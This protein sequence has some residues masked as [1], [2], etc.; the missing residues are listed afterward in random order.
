M[1]KF[2]T[3][4]SLL[5][6]LAVSAMA[7]SAD[8]YY[9]V[10]A[11]SHTHYPGSQWAINDAGTEFVSTG[12]TTVSTDA[13]KH[14]AFVNYENATYIYSV[15]AKK[16]VM[17]DKFL[18]DDPSTVINNS[19]QTEKLSDG[20]YFFKFDNS[21]IINIGGSGQMVI[22][23]WSTKDGGNQYTLTEQ[24]D[25][26]ASEAL[27]ILPTI[28]TITYEFKYDDKV[29]A[30]T[31]ILTS[32]NEPYPACN[33]ADILPLGVNATPPSGI[34][35]TDEKVTIN[36]TIDNSQIPFQYAD[37]YASIE[38][39][40]YMNIRDDGPT[41]LQYDASKNYI[42][43]T[44][45]SVPEDQTDNYTWGFIGDPVNGFKI[46]NYAAGE[47][48]VLSSPAT[49]TGTQNAG[50][51]ARMVAAEGATGNTTWTIMVPNHDNP[52]AENGFYIQH[53][54]AT[55]YA[56]NRQDYNSAKT[57]CYWT[58]RDTGSTLQVVE[59]PMTNARE[60]Q[61]LVEQAQEQL[62]QI[63]IGE[64]V[65]KYSSSYE[66]YETTYSEIIAY[67]QNIPATATSN[68]I[69]SKIDILNA[70]I[71]S[72]SLNMPEKGKY[73]RLQ[74]ISGNYIDATSIYNNATATSGQMSMKSATECNLA[75]T[76]FYLDSDSHLL[77]YATGTYTKETREIGT[78]GY[79]YK[80]IWNIT[81]SP[82]GNAKYALEDTNRENATNGAHLHDNAGNRAD[83]C[84][85][86]CGN[87]HDFTIEAVT[88]LPVTLTAVGSAAWGTLHAPVALE[89][90]AGVEAFYISSFNGDMATMTKVETIPANT[91][92]IL[93]STEADTYNF[94]IVADVA[95]IEG[96]KLEGTV[97]KETKTMDAYILSAGPDGSTIGL[98]PLSTNGTE[99]NSF[100]NG[101]HKAYLPAT[102]IPAASQGSTGFGFRFEDGFTTGIES[103]KAENEEE[104]IVYDLTGRRVKT[105]TAPGI[106]IVN[107]KKVLVK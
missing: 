55:S 27:A 29:L 101:S 1:R 47:T 6:I 24:G 56:L 4:F 71:N 97:A 86:N 54:T 8:K 49:P 43:A 14:F 84:S 2:T 30:T 39:W 19:I 103:A 98:Y 95:A 12:N 59:R 77:N 93:T 60:L 22:D 10:T 104:N 38:H 81:A 52:I 78:V 57:V 13:Q 36:C 11:N 21:H 92:V 3:I 50:E 66:N 82:R 31:E 20:R 48:M 105:A 74:G 37:S 32:K 41:Y 51:L 63:S 94:K 40:Y 96:N 87:R 80:S 34:V 7:Q 18:S 65:G 70:I 99:S 33:T 72:F 68:E 106:Y 79:A 5:L 64:G 17:K 42:P 61:L 91:A 45:T 85:S 90:P 9:T 67:S 25:F 83:R 62:E 44:A 102:N 100:I 15:S 69:Q 88:E 16:F 28:C 107:G 35:T 73:Y 53:P 58:G 89:V 26:D 75:G 76:I 23:G 46:V